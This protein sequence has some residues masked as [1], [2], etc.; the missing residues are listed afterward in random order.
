MLAPCMT[1]LDND[2]D[3]SAFERLYLENSRM[4]YRVAF[5]ILK[6]EGLAEDACAE[7]FLSI[8]KVFRKIHNL[9]SHKMQYYIVV[10]VRN[11]SLNILKKE[12]NHREA[13]S[14]SDALEYTAAPDI[15]RGGELTECIRRLSATDREILYLRVNIGLDYRGIG[16]TLGISAAAARQR[17]RHAKTGLAKMLEKEGEAD[18]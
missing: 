14:Y 10:S 7:A 16:Q 17:Y 8:A 5:A 9:N 6:D 15:A 12:K 2:N 1:L 11:A 18:E 4:A 13:V 3:K